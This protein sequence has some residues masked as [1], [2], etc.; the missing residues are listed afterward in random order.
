LKRPAGASVSS[1]LLAIH[2]A[3]LTGYDPQL[4]TRN[5]ETSRLDTFLT[6]QKRFL[7]EPCCK[8]ASTGDRSCPSYL[9][10]ASRYLSLIYV[11]F[12]FNTPPRLPPVRVT[13][14][15]VWIDSNTRSALRAERGTRHL[16]HFRWL[17]PSSQQLW[18]SRYPRTCMIEKYV[19]RE[20]FWWLVEDSG[21]GRMT[22]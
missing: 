18:H 3:G 9:F 11:L 6:R 20:V 5:K 7:F 10:V 14:R 21:A 2:C 22:D 19:T 17:M 12:S 16:V 1:S 13:C 8:I 4:S 15:F